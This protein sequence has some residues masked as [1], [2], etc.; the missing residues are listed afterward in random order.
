MAWT[1]EQKTE[2]IS[3]YKAANPT[4]ENSTEIIKEIAED[5]EQT[6]NGVRMV[7]VQAG[8]YV[9]KD[10][11]VKTPS[12]TSGTKDTATTTRVSKDSQ[13]AELREAIIKNKAE[14]D[15]EIISKLTCL[16]YTSDAADE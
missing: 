8:V 7:L 12:G 10:T 5:L 6:A 1:E 13:I 11:N 14:V 3:A 15:E 16:L 9:K 2:A 4:P